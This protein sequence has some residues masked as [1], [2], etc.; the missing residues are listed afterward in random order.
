MRVIPHAGWILGLTGTAMAT[1]SAQPAFASS[2]TISSPSTTAQTL[3]SASGQTGLI[4]ATGSLTQTASGSVAVSITGNNE[5]LTNLGSIVETGTG[6][7][8]DVRDKSTVTGLIINNGSSTDSSALMQTADNDVIQMQEPGSTVTLN[9]Y[10][11]LQSLNAS[12]GGAQAVDFNAVTGS[13]TVN[14]Y[15]GGLIEAQYADSV[16]PG[17]NGVVNNWGTITVANTPTGSSDD[18]IDAQ[19]NTGITITNYGTGLISGA[20][21]GITGGNTTGD[22]SFTM[23][24]T[25]NAGGVIQG[26]DGSGVNIDGINGNELVTIVNHGLISGNG[27]TGDGDGVDVDGLVNLTNDGTIRSLN[28][29][30]DTSEGVTV[31]GGTIVNSGTIEGS[32]DAPSG[33]TGTGRGITIAG[34]DKDANDN[35]IPV[36]APYGPTNITNSGLIKG[37]SNSGIAFA[38]AAASGFSNTITNT[39]TGTIEGGGATAVALQT[40]ADNDTVNNSGVIEADSSGK[41]IDL[42]AGNNTLNILGG[43]AAVTGDI[44]GGTGG[45]NV[46]TIDPG[47]G[48]SFT[49]AGSLSNFSVVQ[50]KSGQVTLSGTSSYSGMTQVS[51]G[52]LTLQ[53]ANRIAS[54]SALDL[55]GGTLALTNAGGANGQTFASLSLTGNSIIDLGDSSLS[56][57]GLGT[58]DANDSLT[59]LDW[60][61]SSSPGYAL[62]LVGN[63]TD[64]AAFLSLLSDTT[65][66]GLAVTDRF[67]GVY[68]DVAPVPL[69]ASWPLL[70]SALAGL[71]LMLRRRGAP[72]V[73]SLV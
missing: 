25:N 37:D 68:T 46:M 51:G 15:A 69:P 26:N 48:G 1:L 40:G 72:L 50:T 20:R 2:F 13:N 49:Y 41:A 4:T 18:G 63:D 32:I 23:N 21:H 16:R 17:V 71:A 14:N 58:L 65:I 9:N 12:Q 53:G 52:T 36:Q 34:V 45:T 59:V 6:S 64:D 22:G 5:T 38:S 47:S 30:N 35:P 3:G 29:L 39:A 67:D 57:G 60:S 55:D 56:F 24:I 33:N 8:R 31:G 27:V 61:G 54:G 70:L 43:A 73:D 44:S 11:V 7:S 42:G 19:A 62:R 28:A 66:D 10:G